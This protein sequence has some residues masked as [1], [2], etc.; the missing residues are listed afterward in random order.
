MASTAPA[1]FRYEILSS[2]ER[3]AGGQGCV[4]F[5]FDKFDRVECAAK[6]FFERHTFEHERALYSDPSLRD[7]MVAT[8]EVCGNDD[9]G[10]LAANGTPYPSFIVLERG[11]SLDEW[12]FRQSA[13]SSGGAAPDIV[14]AVQVLLSHPV[15][16]CAT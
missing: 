3:R 8:R 13:G 4:Q 15:W 10:M 9:G 2:F 5:V 14:T 16:C 11:E 1:V 6:F 12:Q 7:V